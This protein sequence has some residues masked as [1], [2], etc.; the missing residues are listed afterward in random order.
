MILYRSATAAKV[1]PQYR[2]ARGARP[3]A[4]PPYASAAFDAAVQAV[5]SRCA[6]CIGETGATWIDRQVD[7]ILTGAFRQGPLVGISTSRR[8]RSPAWVVEAI[9]D[10]RA[11]D[12]YRTNCGRMTCLCRNLSL[13][14]IG[15]FCFLPV[16]MTHHRLLATGRRNPA[17]E[18]TQRSWISLRS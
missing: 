16:K 5:C 18:L 4:G 10:K 17:I 2:H 11:R 6:S 15:H 14:E 3:R 7:D 13:G 1:K 9:A 12:R 8:I